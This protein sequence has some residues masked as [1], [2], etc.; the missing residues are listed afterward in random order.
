MRVS[1]F[2][3]LLIA[4]AVLVAATHRTA[5]A[6]PLRYMVETV[7][8]VTGTIGAVDGGPGTSLLTWPWALCQGRSEDEIL[9]GVPGFFRNYSRSTRMT[10]T[11]LGNGTAAEVDGSWAKARID[12]PQGCV[13]SVRNNNT[14]VYFVEGQNTLRYFTSNSVLSLALT[15]GVSF[16]DVAVY[17]DRLYITEQTQNKVWSCNLEADGTPSHCAPQT[18]FVCGYPRYN[19]IAV[20]ALGVFVAS[21]SGVGVCHF[22]GQG[23][24]LFQLP[25]KY[26]DVFSL[27]SGALYAAS[28]VQLYH[29]LPN[30][31]AMTA[32]VFAGNASATCPPA[33]DGY[34]FTL[35]LNKRLF[36][37]A[38]NEMYLATGLNT[39]RAVTLPPA[40]VP[41][42]LPPPPLP[43]G[44]PDAPTVMPAIVALINVALNANLG[45]TGTYAPQSA[46]QVNNATWTTGFEVMVQQAD[47][48]NTT[49]P[50]LVA[51]TDFA[52]VMQAVATYYD[53]ID[54]AL[55]MDTSIV[56]Y[57]NA[58]LMNI[59][60]H[61]LVAVVRRA[62]AYPLIYANPPMKVMFKDVANVTRMKLLMPVPFGNSTTYDALENLNANAAL[63]D[64]LRAQ[65]GST[66]VVQLVFPVSQYDFSK[67]TP[68]QDTQVRW[69][70]LNMVNARLETCKSITP[71]GIRAAVAAV[72]AERSGGNDPCGAVISNRT[73]TVVTHPPFNVQNE[74]EVFVPQ[75]YN[76][77]VTRCLQGIDWEPLAELLRN[78]TANASRGKSA[79]DR[80]CIIGVAVVAAVV[81]TA[82][83]VLVVVLTSKRK[84]L[85]TVVAPVQP[86]FKST[87][88]DDEELETSNPLEANN[89]EQ[90]R[91]RY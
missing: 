79:C 40:I 56:P 29:L 48:D 25:G 81:L 24:A 49:T 75:Q 46:M 52:A 16:T 17:G 85:A 43:L 78:Q 36:V 76:F 91:E 57:C 66:N 22:D 9:I 5:A 20:T 2:P 53:T 47:F 50:G 6:M 73:E 74:Y 64:I 39:V 31:S 72:A 70:I 83:I 21:G 58:A 90:A 67:I 23:T 86:K 12:I 63:L 27:P 42:Q 71:P 14:I 37:V 69:F 19:S 60:E 35:C 15:T 1:P 28:S 80:G 41:A 3:I 30:A 7:S 84:R 87:L 59:V 11:L 82:L 45:T 68:A 88:D 61:G 10:G 13:L 65:Y 32:E 54:E 55:Y 18:G 26:I 34:S 8:G 38:E 51:A 44:Y 33:V 77:N 62:L 4:T 89:E